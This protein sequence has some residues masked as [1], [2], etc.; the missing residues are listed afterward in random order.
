MLTDDRLYAIC[1]VVMPLT[2][3]LKTKAVDW[4]ILQLITSIVRKTR[5]FC[6]LLSYISMYF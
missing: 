5:D 3:I 2:F 4:A 6:R 1:C